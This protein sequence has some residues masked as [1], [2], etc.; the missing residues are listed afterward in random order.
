MNSLLPPCF[1]LGLVEQVVLTD[2]RSDEGSY[3]KKK[4]ELTNLVADEAGDQKDF[5]TL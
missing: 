1:P 2:G 5:Q 4:K 3:L